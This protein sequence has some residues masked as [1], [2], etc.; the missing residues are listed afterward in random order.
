MRGVGIATTRRATARM[1]E[2]CFDCPRLCGVNRSVTVGFCGAPDRPRIARAAPH[3]GEEPCLSGTRGAGAVFFSGCSLR[4]I[5]C[6][7]FPI[8]HLG[9]GET[10][11]PERLLAIFSELEEQGVHNLDLVTPTH[12]TSLLADLLQR[13][14]QRLP[15][16]WNSSGYERV[17][18]LRCLEGSV[19]V[20]LPDLKYHSEEAAEL[21]DAKDY[22]KVASSALLEMARQVGEPEFDQE[23]LLRRG[24]LV[25]HLVLPGLSKDSVA[26][27][28]WCAA[29]LP[30]GTRYSIMAQ[31]TPTEAVRD[32][33]DLN[34][35]LTAFEYDR[36]AQAAL[37][38]NLKG[39]F[40][41]RSAAGEEEIPAFDGTGVGP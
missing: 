18:L 1:Y 3:F 37:R 15:V 14:P 27:L 5:Y 19:D 21:S 40:Q 7:N 24:L 38:L 33:R 6:Q 4:C 23:G 29:N 32:R 26:L 20:Y 31:Y 35:R 8:S 9:Q 16:V 10:V 30:E 28:E 2:R 22:F 13:H 39:Y 34:R 17:E 36:V 12:Y 41:E 11:G 25:R